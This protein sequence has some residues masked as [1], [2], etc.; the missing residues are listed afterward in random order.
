L[1]I[2]R[3]YARLGAAVLVVLGTMVSTPVAAEDGDE[4]YW[5]GP[6]KISF[7]EARKAQRERDL[8]RP[9]FA[10]SVAES[11]AMLAVG[12][13]WYW[14]SRDLNSQDWDIEPNFR[15]VSRRFTTLDHI[16]FDS[17]EF[18]VNEG[19]VGAGAAY[20]GLPRTSGFGPLGSLAFAALTSAAWEWGLEF[21]EHV[22]L[23]D[24]I[25]SPYGGQALGEVLYK[26]GE[27]R[28]TMREDLS[29]PAR[30]LTAPFAA[31][32][33]FHDWVD[34]VGRPDW[35]ASLGPPMSHDFRA[36]AGVRVRAAEEGVVPL[37]AFGLETTV[38]DIP[39]YERRGRFDSY[40][41]DGNHTRLRLDLAFDASR[42][43]TFEMSARA[44][45]LGYYTQSISELGRG[46]SLMVGLTRG[47]W[48]ATENR[49]DFQEEIG[50]VDLLG[51][52]ILFTGYVGPL[53]LGTEFSLFLDL[54][55]VHSQAFAATRDLYTAGQV[56]TELER[57]G[58]YFGWGVLLLPGVWAEWGPVRLEGEARWVRFRELNF[59]D[60]IHGSD[61]PLRLD[62]FDERLLLRARLEVAPH[63]AAAIRAQVERRAR[64]SGIEHRGAATDTVDELTLGFVF[65]F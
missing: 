8:A 6:R 53:R 27:L 42:L 31:P 65:R 48:V 21:R 43:D 13:A 47:A 26:W 54:G 50:M 18:W 37:G 29:W 25:T 44:I 59:P 5:I 56:R 2:A 61:V 36:H 19:H 63:P 45:L 7:E 55:S 58:Y 40:F 39:G 60:R 10:R 14:A 32:A 12:G 51:P 34:G 15:A 46:V 38:V 3:A 20:Y 23:N 49:P 64:R 22:S 4:H 57:E 1:G 9:K 28:R 41:A 24:L 52:R 16:R 33:A 11:L 62:L 35:D 17:N 30:T